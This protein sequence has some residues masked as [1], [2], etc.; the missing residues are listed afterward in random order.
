MP[1]RQVK[2]IAAPVLRRMLAYARN[3]EYPERNRAIVLLSVKAGLRAAEIAQLTW[4]M[5]LDARGRVGDV[6]TV[7]DRIA[8][9]GGWASDPDASRPRQ[10]S[11]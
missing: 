7:P 1:G 6:I 5:V 2:L 11:P 9:K 4:P 10:D 8:K 3:T